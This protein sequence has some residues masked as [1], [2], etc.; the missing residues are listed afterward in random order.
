MIELKS[1]STKDTLYEEVERLWIEAFPIY[2]RRDCE[3]Q[4][5][6]TDKN[7]A[8]V[9]F[10]AIERIDPIESEKKKH[11]CEKNSDFTH[12]TEE[13]LVGMVG[14]WEIEDFVYIEHLATLSTLRNNGYGA[15]IIKA[16][17]Q[18]SAIQSGKKKAIVLEVESEEDEWAKRR[19]G[20]YKRQGFTLWDQKEYIQPPY[21]KGDKGYKMHLM[22]W[23][24][25]V[26]EDKDFE[27]IK[28][29]IHKHVYG[30]G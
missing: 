21:R 9:C 23:G 22:V 29:A 16:I 10:A 6:N 15:Q 25:N 27:R 26:R 28:R 2:E 5:A 19:I 18:Y 14:Y 3:Q 17:K 13:R 30:V 8:F 7:E 20:F 24:E 1:I 4:R 12:V 11:N